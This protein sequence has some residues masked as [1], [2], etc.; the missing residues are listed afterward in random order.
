[1]KKINL[2]FNFNLIA[3]YDKLVF[4]PNPRRDWAVLLGGFVVCFIIVSVF[5]AY[6]YLYLRD[7]ESVLG[8]D[9]GYGAIDEERLNQAIEIIGE[10]NRRQ[11]DS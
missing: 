10:R 8:P 7:V 4:V 3:D 5:H 11:L 6:V 9:I 2:K 1:M